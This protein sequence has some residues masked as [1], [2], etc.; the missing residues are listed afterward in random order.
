MVSFELVSISLPE[1]G[2][3]LGETFALAEIGSNLYAVTGA[4][5]LPGQRSAADPCVE[6]QLIW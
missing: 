2:D 4:G 5:V 1:V 6:C 3:R